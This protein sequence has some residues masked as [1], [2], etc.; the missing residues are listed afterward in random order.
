LPEPRLSIADEGFSSYENAQLELRMIYP[1]N[2]YSREASHPGAGVS[3]DFLTPPTSAGSAFITVVVIFD[4][5]D[6]NRTLAHATYAFIHDESMGGTGFSLVSVTTT[7]L[8]RAIANRVEFYWQQPGHTQGHGIM[9][10]AV[11]G[12][13]LY[14]AGYEANSPVLFDETHKA[15]EAAIKSIEY[16]GE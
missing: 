16:I 1:K 12:R 13:R 15:A 11:K 2:W 5:H 6:Q 4:W 7:S 3:V 10:I 9:Y 14:M 8:L